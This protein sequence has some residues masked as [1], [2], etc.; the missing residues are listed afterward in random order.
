MLEY[1][2]FDTSDIHQDREFVKTLDTSG[3]G[4][5]LQQ[6]NYDIYPLSPSRIQKSILDILGR[7]FFHSKSSLTKNYLG[8]RPKIITNL[9]LAAF[10]LIWCSFGVLQD[11]F[12]HPLVGAEPVEPFFNLLSPKPRQLTFRVVPHILF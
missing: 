12:Q 11:G 5:S 10:I 3:G 9:P 8:G 4:S 6:V 2:H 7:L 1:Q